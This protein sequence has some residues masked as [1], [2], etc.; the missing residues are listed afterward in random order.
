MLPMSS[1]SVESYLFTKEGMSCLMD[2]L[3]NDGVL[4]IDVGGTANDSAI[5]FVAALEGLGHYDLYWYIVSDYPMVGLPLFFIFASRNPEAIERLRPE[6]SKI[7]AIER[8]ER[9]CFEKGCTGDGYVAATDDRPFL[10]PY[11][12]GVRAAGWLPVVVMLVFV[13]W[14]LRRVRRR[15]PDDPG[16]PLYPLFIA[17][18]GVYGATE[19]VLV[20]QGSRRFFDPALASTLLISL[21]LVGGALA[22]FLHA[23]WAPAFGHKVAAM[24]TVLLA[25]RLLLEPARERPRSCSCPWR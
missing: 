23:R 18:G 6:L 8:V 10:Y 20:L 4:L 15:E 2:S 17:L 21:F 11:S 14:L 3:T 19:S 5:P 16:L 1:V 7:N 22:N 9:P 13:R 25:V 24:V 12:G